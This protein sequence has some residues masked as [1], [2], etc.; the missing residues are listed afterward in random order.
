LE[1]SNTDHIPALAAAGAGARKREAITWAQQ[2]GVIA[3]P[4]TPKAILAVINALSMLGF[5][6]GD[7]TDDVARDRALCDRQTI[8]KT[9]RSMTE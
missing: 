9:L 7:Q 2:S 4:F 3:N 8:I 6:D 1:C 5:P